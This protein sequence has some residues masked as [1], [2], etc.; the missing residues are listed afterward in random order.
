VFERSVTISLG[1]VMIGCS[2]SS[3]VPTSDAEYPQA[4]VW[5]E[6][7]I[8]R[9]LT[10][11]E[12]MPT[13]NAIV[14]EIGRLGDVFGLEES[15][16]RYDVVMDTLFRTRERREAQQRLQQRLD[17]QILEGP[18]PH[19]IPLDSVADILYPIVPVAPMEESPPD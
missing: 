12:P 6:K 10:E 8:L 16:R 9:Q 19:C 15:L 18:G 17:G 11:D 7:L 14:C 5:L 2:P 3:S 4:T 13:F 1:V